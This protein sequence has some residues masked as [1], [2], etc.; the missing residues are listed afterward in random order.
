MSVFSTLFFHVSVCTYINIYI[1]IHPKQGQ[2]NHYLAEG[3][4]MP[5]ECDIRMKRMIGEWEMSENCII[6][7]EN[8]SSI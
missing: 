5:I 1:K 7:T 4:D 2:T 8:G 3:S 6:W